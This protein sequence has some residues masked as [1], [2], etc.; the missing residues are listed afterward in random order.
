MNISV[1]GYKKSLEKPFRIYEID[2]DP[3]AGKMVPGSPRQLS[4]GG[5]AETKAMRRQICGTKRGFDDM[6]PCYLPNGKIIFASSRAQ[7]IV[8]C[9]PNTATTLYIILNVSLPFQY[10]TL[11]DAPGDTV[12][13]SL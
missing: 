10:R 9:A 4:T 1:F 11:E 12:G 6:H 5:E 3:V 8:F 7:R 2:I 13:M